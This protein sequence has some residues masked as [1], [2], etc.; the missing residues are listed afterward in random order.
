MDF[1]QN[2]Y[3]ISLSKLYRV[4]SPMV[5]NVSKNILLQGLDPES[6]WLWSGISAI[7]MGGGEKTRKGMPYWFSWACALR[8]IW[9][10][11]IEK[12]IKEYLHLSLLWGTVQHTKDDVLVLLQWKVMPLV[13]QNLALFFKTC[14]SPLKKLK[15]V[16][17]SPCGHLGPWVSCMPSSVRWTMAPSCIINWFLP[18][19]FY[20]II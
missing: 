8:K 10:R 20:C 3:L 1:S 14:P 5:F 16:C 19:F 17:T 7:W 9:K 15:C 13:I 6:K 11:D 4:I 12:I 2:Y 18:L